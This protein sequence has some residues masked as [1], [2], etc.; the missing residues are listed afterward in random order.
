MSF[1]LH[2]RSD[3]SA[4]T[5]PTESVPQPYRYA[6]AYSD[7]TGLYKMGYR[8]YDPSLGRFTQPDPSGRRP[9]RTSTPRQTPST[10]V[11]LRCCSASPTSAS[12]PR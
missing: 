5:T 12:K 8:Y 4:R 3:G 9:T 10:M 2:L 11:T 7:P 6:G 1:S